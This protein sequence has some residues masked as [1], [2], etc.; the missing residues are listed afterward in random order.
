MS[1]RSLTS[2][3]VSS[4]ESINASQMSHRIRPNRR[5]NTF[6]KGQIYYTRTHE[7]IQLASACELPGQKTTQNATSNDSNSDETKAKFMARIGVTDYR[8][9]AAGDFYKVA[10]DQLD[11]E[12]QD[13]F[14]KGKEVCEID[15]STDLLESFRMPVTAR[16]TN[17]NNELLTQPLLANRDPENLGW[18]AEVEIMNCEQLGGLMS[19]GEYQD[20]LRRTPGCFTMSCEI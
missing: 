16:I 14:I 18:L 4:I 13:V 15:T 2:R 11:L 17:I 6:F 1:L 12:F 9:L 20:F 3:V 7:W 8:A 10:L 19:K 5:S